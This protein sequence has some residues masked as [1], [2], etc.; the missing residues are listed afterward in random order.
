MRNLRLAITLLILLLGFNLQSKDLHKIDIPIE[1]AVGLTET[2]LY[3]KFPETRVPTSSFLNL[4]S[5]NMHP[6]HAPKTNKFLRLGSQYLVFELKCGKVI[7][8]HKV[9]G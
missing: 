5:K 4:V 3:E 9:S 8:V 6:Y 7:A 1:D 2:E